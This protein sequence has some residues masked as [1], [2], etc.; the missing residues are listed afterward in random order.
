MN[1]CRYL[2][3]INHGGRHYDM[4]HL[5][6]PSCQSYLSFPLPSLL[7]LYFIIAFIYFLSEFLSS[8]RCLGLNNIYVRYV[9]DLVLDF[10]F[11]HERG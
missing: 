9:A 10:G 7:C 6:L 4:V 1:K 8:F 11:V 2:K 5:F 3:I